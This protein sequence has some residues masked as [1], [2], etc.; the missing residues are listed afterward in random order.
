MCSWLRFLLFHILS[1]SPRM[2][3]FAIFFLHALCVTATNR[4]LSLG[5]GCTLWLLKCY[6]S[7]LEIFEVVS[8]LELL[9]VAS[10]LDVLEVGPLG[11]FLVPILLLLYLTYSR[12]FSRWQLFCSSTT[13]DW[14]VAN[15]RLLSFS[16]FFF[17]VYSQVSTATNDIEKT[18]PTNIPFATW[19]TVA[20]QTVKFDIAKLSCLFLYF[21]FFL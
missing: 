5:F 3:I 14:W 19:M 17:N 8:F 7:F 21:N 12:W 11:C 1:L 16:S 4:I 13:L 20:D 2:Q 18:T 10:F 9:E 6:A 15:G